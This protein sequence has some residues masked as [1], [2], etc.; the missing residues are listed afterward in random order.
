MLLRFLG[1]ILG[2]LFAGVAAR[3]TWKATRISWMNYVT[4]AGVALGF[5]QEVCLPTNA[6]HASHLRTSHPEQASLRTVLADD[7]TWLQAIILRFAQ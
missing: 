6:D 3:D 2:S 7:L 5:A 4:Q 1:I